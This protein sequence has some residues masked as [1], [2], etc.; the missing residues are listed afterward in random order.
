MV[1]KDV[2]PFFINL[3][4][5]NTEYF[6]QISSQMLLMAQFTLILHQNVQQGLLNQMALEVLQKANNLLS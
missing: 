4:T 2:V 5:T 6:M 3:L 1:Q